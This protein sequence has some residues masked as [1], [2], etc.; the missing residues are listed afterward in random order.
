[1]KRLIK[2]LIIFSSCWFTKGRLDFIM[3]KLISSTIFIFSSCGNVNW[4]RRMT[5]NMC[6]TPKYGKQEQRTGKL[7]HTVNYLTHFLNFNTSWL[8]NGNVFHEGVGYTLK[9]LI[10]CIHK[11]GGHTR[12]YLQYINL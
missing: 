5:C 8:S 9:S 3:K 2:S 6:N 1:M 12:Y 7:V 4:A 11:G 10:E